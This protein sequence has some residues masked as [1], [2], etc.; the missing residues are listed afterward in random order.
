MKLEVVSAK[1]RRATGVMSGSGETQLEAERR[2]INDK[3]SKIKKELAAE[4]NNQKFL[5]QKRK[6]HS[7]QI[8]KIAL[9][10]TYN[11]KYFVNFEL[12]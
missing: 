2:L 9:V 11:Y 8:P 1:Q 12:K 10:R 5:R 6:T 4:A 3:E 7:D